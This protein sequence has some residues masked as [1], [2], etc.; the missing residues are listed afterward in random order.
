MDNK[1]IKFIVG[2]YFADELTALHITIKDQKTV[3][4]IQFAGRFQTGCR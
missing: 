4:N 3:F 2:L 1:N